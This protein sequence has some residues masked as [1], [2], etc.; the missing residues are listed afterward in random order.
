MRCEEARVALG[1]DDSAQV[2]EHV[3]GCAECQAYERE[4]AALARLLDADADVE[5]RPGFDTRFFARLKAEKQRDRRG[6]LR[7]FGWAALAAGATA[8]AGVA[9]VVLWRSGQPEPQLDPADL[10]LALHLDLLED[11]DVI[12]NLHDLEDFE[13]LAGVEDLDALTEQGG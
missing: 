7:R 10:E 13:I 2:R 8:A 1:H 9:G 4:L 6:I 5:P 12:R 11:L 3:G